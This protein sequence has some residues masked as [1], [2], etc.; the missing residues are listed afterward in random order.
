MGAAADPENGFQTL[1]GIA[2]GFICNG[3]KP[4]FH[5]VRRA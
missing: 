5:T 4:K 2:G 1:K 3:A